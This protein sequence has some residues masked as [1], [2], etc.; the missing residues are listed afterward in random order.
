[1][2]QKHLFVFVGLLIAISLI[3]GACQPAATEAPTEAPT[4]EVMEE[5]TEEMEEPTEEMEEPT[6]EMEEPTEEMMEGPVEEGKFW[7][8]ERVQAVAAAIDREAL[9]DRVFEGRNIPAYHMVPPGYPYATEPFL[10]MYGTRDLDMS[11]QLLTDL[12]YTE[13]N[14]FTFELWYPPEHYG[15]TTADVMQVIKEQL[16]ETGLIQ[17]ELTSQNWA[18]YVDS[19]V[20]G[21][22]PVFILGWFPDFADPE[23][24]LSP[25]GSCLQSPDLGVNYCD[26]ALDELLLQAASSSDAEE[27]ATLYEEI[28]NYWAENVPTFPLFWEPEFVTY[29]DGVEGVMIGAP[30]E[31]NYN[32]LSFGEGAEPASGSTD[33]IIIGT[34]DEVHSLDAQDAYATHDWEILKNTGVPLLKYEAGTSDLVLGAAAE[35]PTPSEDGTQWT[36]TLK[37]G[38]TFADGTPLTAQDYVRSWERI[39]LE[40]DVSGLMQLYIESVEAPDDST[41]VFNLTAP[42]GFFP[43][44]SATAP[45][46]PSNPNQ[47]PVDEL[48]FFPETID[49]IGPYRMVSYTAGEQMVLEANTDYFGEDAPIIPTVIVRYFADPTTMANAVESGEIDVAWRVLGPVE[50]TRLMDVEGLTV[51]RIDA[52]TLRY[53]VFNHTYTF[54]HEE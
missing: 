40:G 24:W 3:L 39:G 18:E 6:E 19:F 28:G 41:V 16:E 36:F 9:V 1:M 38:I 29:R 44:L 20:D 52:P 22:L 5:P 15:T 11:I 46:I 51:E 49:G 37:D 21:D 2:K 43:A 50:A 32:V 35:M 31:F 25:F 30:F 14:P 4:E 13:D 53:L 54:E 34:T 27:R 7:T 33:T 47:Y 48:V 23:N 42:F 26:E 17:V 45:L 10:D 12:G 8:P